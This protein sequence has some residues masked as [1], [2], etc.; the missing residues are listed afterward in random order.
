MATVWTDVYPKLGQ[1]SLIPA[2]YR[3]HV[4]FNWTCIKVQSSRPVRG[5][6]RVC[7][8]VAVTL[9]VHLFGAS[10]GGFLAQKFAEY[11]HKSPRVHS[12]ILCNSFSDTSIFNQTWTANRCFW[13]MDGWWMDQSVWSISCVLCCPSVSGWCQRSCWRRL[14]WETLQKDL[15]TLKWQMQLISW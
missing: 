7:D 10:L 4:V 6:P 15:W 12:L 1:L 3:S 5:V 11:T 13:W 8:G 2:G 9:Q 14:F